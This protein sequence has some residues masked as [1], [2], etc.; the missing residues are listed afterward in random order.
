MSDMLVMTAVELCPPVA[1]VVA[2]VSGD[3]PFHLLLVGAPFVTY[4]ELVIRRDAGFHQK[5]SVRD[6]I[7]QTPDATTSGISLS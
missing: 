2:I 4:P 5:N 7:Q 3:A 1:G 6:T